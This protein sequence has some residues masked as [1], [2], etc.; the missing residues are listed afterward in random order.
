MDLL[1]PA[2]L[3][4]LVVVLATLAFFLLSKRSSTKGGRVLLLGEMGSV[5]H[6]SSPSRPPTLAHPNYG[7]RQ[8]PLPSPPPTV[9]PPIYPRCMTVGQERT[10]LP[11]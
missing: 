4:A 11:A 6:S 10:L 1:D 2:V 7:S 9:L 3:V 5:P 8:P